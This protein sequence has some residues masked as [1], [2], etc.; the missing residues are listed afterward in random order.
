[1]ANKEKQDAWQKF[2]QA[3]GTRCTFIEKGARCDN[4]VHG[5]TTRCTKHQEAK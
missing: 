3:Q 4:G 5:N 1:M 2:C